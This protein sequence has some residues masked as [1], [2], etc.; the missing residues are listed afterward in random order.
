MPA[1]KRG[2]VLDIQHMGFVTGLSMLSESG[3]KAYER[4]F[5]TELNASSVEAL[6]VLS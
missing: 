3:R 1:S 6:K 4:F 5:D 2:E